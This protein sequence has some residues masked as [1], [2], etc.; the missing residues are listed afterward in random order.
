MRAVL[1]PWA[2]SQSHGDDVC[3]CRARARMY[4][5]MAVAGF[6]PTGT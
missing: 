5:S 1:C 3:E 2:P 6:L 4:L